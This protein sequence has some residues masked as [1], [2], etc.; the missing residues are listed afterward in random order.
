MSK[1]ANPALIGGFVLL[2]LIIA[3]AAILFLGSGQ[4]F[5]D[6]TQYILYFEGD[7]S[8]L[9]VGAPVTYR[10]VTIGQVR[11]I[12]LVYDHKDGSI[13]IPVIIEI[14]QGSVAEDNLDDAHEKEDQT[15]RLIQRGMRA[16]LATSSLVT[17]KLKVDLDHY[18]GTKIVYRAGDHPLVEIP[19]IPGALDTLAKRI[20]DLPLEEIVVDLRETTAGISELVQ[21]GALEKTVEELNHTLRSI[22]TAVNSAELAETVITLR[23]SL[24]QSRDLIHEFRVGAKP[25]RRELT[26]AIEEFGEAA[27]VARSFIDYIERH[28]ESLLRGK[29]SK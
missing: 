3:V 26:V 17:G 22:S 8:G 2:A 11:K 7:L 18:P 1:K 19:T 15:E 21:S 25:I 12:S 13:S 20:S 9:D 4:I 29:E 5:K 16:R 10:G 28:P 6:S 27:R 14:M 23:D 24:A